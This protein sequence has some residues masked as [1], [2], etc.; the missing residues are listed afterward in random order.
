MSMEK[1]DSE[2]E[3]RNA[4]QKLFLEI[5]NY[6]PPYKMYKIQIGGE[7][8]LLS[9]ASISS[10]G[11]NSYFLEYFQNVE[12]S[13]F[14]QS[15]HNY[16]TSNGKV[17]V[18][19][20]EQILFIDRDPE[21]FRYIYNHLQ[22]YFV[23][24][25][26]EIVFSK[27]FTDAMYYG[28]P[29]LKKILKESESYYVNIGGKSFK[30][31]K[32]LF[33]NDGNNKNYF[34]L[35]GEM[36][37]RDLEELF[38]KSK[39][40]KILRPPPQMW[41]Y[42][43]RSAKLFEKILDL[44]KNGKFEG[45][46]VE[47][48]NLLKE[49]KFYRLLK[50]EQELISHKFFINPFKNASEIYLNLLDIKVNEKNIGLIDVEFESS[51]SQSDDSGESVGKK[52][53]L[54]PEAQLQEITVADL[55]QKEQSTKDALNMLACDSSSTF[56]SPECEIWNVLSYSRPYVDAWKYPLVFQI[57]N[58]F[59]EDE[60]PKAV[61]HCFIHTVETIDEAGNVIASPN[62]SAFFTD[63]DCMVNLGTLIFD[64]DNGRCYVSFEGLVAIKLYRMLKLLLD[65]QRIKQKYVFKYS[66]TN[67]AVVQRIILPCCVQMCVVKMDNK[68]IKNLCGLLKEKSFLK[69][70]EKCR[71]EN[72]ENR[73]NINGFKIPLCD[74]SVW[75]LG[76][77][78]GENNAKSK[79]EVMMIAMKIRCGS[80]KEY[81]NYF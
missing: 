20:E 60:K 6:L 63:P 18:D 28:L 49:C 25:P 66:E 30:I 16:T 31:S 64:A 34:K 55:C 43:S 72:A 24:I 78:K 23:N 26:N 19:V 71:V 53:K 33:N 27:L 3:S 58:A 59:H 29:R 47:R 81:N 42:C 35:T 79:D 39:G 14:N 13:Q 73:N 76:F 5:P 17:N 38:M 70:L 4:N 74:R 67:S 2:I 45:S 22:G 36:I 75:R 56:K 44:L 57:G 61:D 77:K 9:G 62:S 46:L 37:F 65:E 52:R 51:E 80:I 21:I 1:K 12:K 15:H 48:H 69:N 32:N 41:S 8:F 50:L 7:L 68:P 54:N 40:K 11:P 10:D